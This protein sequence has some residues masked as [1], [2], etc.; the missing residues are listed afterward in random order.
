MLVL[1]VKKTG[2][3]RACGLGAV[4]SRPHVVVSACFEA[5]K[6]KN[7]NEF[8]AKRGKVIQMTLSIAD[9]GFVFLFFP[10]V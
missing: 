5:R 1:L 8:T 9:R 7:F 10:S 4:K 3:L 6:D 2:D